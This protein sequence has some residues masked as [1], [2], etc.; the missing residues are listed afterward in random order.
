M[1]QTDFFVIL[2]VYFALFVLNNFIEA[3]WHKAYS[4]IVMPHK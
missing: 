2:G 1:I 3:F 4:E